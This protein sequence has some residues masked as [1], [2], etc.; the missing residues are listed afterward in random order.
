MIQ[1]MINDDWHKR[2]LSEVIVA[3]PDVAGGSD[4]ADYSP[5]R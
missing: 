4:V 5:W 3:D 2:V 1:G